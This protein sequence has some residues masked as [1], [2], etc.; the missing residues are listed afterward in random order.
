MEGLRPENLE[1]SPFYKIRSED[2]LI[3][4]VENGHFLYLSPENAEKAAGFFQSKIQF[5]ENL[6]VSERYDL[7]NKEQEFKNLLI[8]KATKKEL[9]YGDNVIRVDELNKFALYRI[10]I[11]Q[12]FEETMWLDVEG[13]L[14]EKFMLE[15]YETNDFAEVV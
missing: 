1:N 10:L 6:S 4:I 14:I 5:A 7:D 3:P 12:D 2:S 13:G 9:V 8:E 15:T 11:G